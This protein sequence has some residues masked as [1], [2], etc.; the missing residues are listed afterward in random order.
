MNKQ[1]FITSIINMEKVN[2]PAIIVEETQNVG[3]EL[4]YNSNTLEQNRLENSLKYYDSLYKDR[5]DNIPALPASI[6]THIVA[7]AFGAE[8]A[9]F[10]DGRHYLKGPLINQAA[11]IDHLKKPD[12]LCSSIQQQLDTI[13]VLLD[14]SDDQ[15]MIRSGDHTGPLGVAEMLWQSDDFYTSILMNPDKVHQLLDR[16]TDFMIEFVH[17]MRNLSSRVFTMPWPPIWTPNELGIYIS[18]DTMSMLSPE[19]YEEFSVQ[20]NNRISDEFG[21]IYLHSCVTK[22]NYFESIIKNKN[23]RSINFAAQYSAPLEKFYNYFGGKVVIMPHYWHQ[24]NPQ[25]A[26]L[27][28]FIGNILD[29]WKPEY[30][31][32]IYVGPTT[33]GGRQ[34]E[35]FAEIANHNINMDYREVIN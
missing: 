18:D 19:L 29:L 10:E 26:P 11:D 15:T 25:P 13:K 17:A 14:N 9:T 1:E 28:K 2:R 4:A 34:D 22:E 30:P 7:A 20:Y 24:D 12:L 16:I 6:G 31:T 3:Y 33:A 32:M 23:L 27:P 5:D 35:V 8:I 21:G